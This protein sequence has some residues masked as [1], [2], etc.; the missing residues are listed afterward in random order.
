MRRPAPPARRPRLGPLAPLA[1]A[2]CLGACLPARF[3]A[4]NFATLAQPVREAPHQVAD[5]VR[6]DARLAALWV[7][8]ATVLLQIDDKFVLTDPVFTDSVGQVSRRVVAPGIDVDRVP[9][10]EAIVV[11]HTHFDHL[12][13]S[14]LRRLEGRAKRLFVPAG[15]LVYVP[16]YAF[17]VTPLAPFAART[18]PDGLTVTAV[19][20][21]HVGGRYGIDAQWM[22]ERAHTGYVISYHGINVFFGGDTAYER[23]FFQKTKERFDR[24]DLAILP[25]APVNPR[26]FMRRTH[27]D[28]YEALQAFDDL[29]AERMMPI[30]FDTF[31]NST[32]E[33]GEARERFKQLVA[34]RKFAPGRVSVLEIGEQRVFVPR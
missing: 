6:P 2:A 29:G 24:I 19:P 21:D 33:P 15:A 22:G 17:P 30:H 26:D 23:E 16:N 13:L 25:I 27:M 9:P 7:G 20:V 31:V 10:L 8:H 11:S 4:R 5:P 34:A 28:P 12:S 18:S 1:L 32:D 3:L 14:S